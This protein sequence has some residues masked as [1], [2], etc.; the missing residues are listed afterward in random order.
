M[1]NLLITLSAKIKELNATTMSAQDKW[2]HLEIHNELL[3]GTVEMKHFIACGQD[4]KPITEPVPGDWFD[5]N[6]KL[7]DF[8]IAD[9]A[10]FGLY[11]DKLNDYQEALKSVIFVGWEVVINSSDGVTVT[12]KEVE[13]TFIGKKLI[14]TINI[15]GE[16]WTDLEYINIFED[17]A[18]KTA[19][20]PLELRS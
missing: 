6:K 8:S 19:S 10:G 12:N 3:G 2:E 17:L 16:Y 1:K 5:T 9:T 14:I 11:G 15:G 18:T 4:G 20:N 7:S 13:L